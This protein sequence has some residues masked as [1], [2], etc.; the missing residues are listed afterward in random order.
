MNRTHVLLELLCSVSLRHWRGAPRLHTLLVLIIATGVAAFLA[1]RLANRAV[2]A[3]FERFAAGLSRESLLTITRSEPPLALE[4]LLAIRDAAAP[5]PIH[6]VPSI[7]RIAVRFDQPNGTNTPPDPN[8]TV[9][10]VGVDLVATINLLSASKTS[11]EDSAAP[12]P[13]SLTTDSSP[14]LAA[15]PLFESFKLGESK[16]QAR[17]LSGD[18]PVEFPL[19][20]TIPS[21]NGAPAP[22]DNLILMDLLRMSELFKTQGAFDRIDLFSSE[23]AN[24]DAEIVARA[25]RA[26]DP[27]LLIQTPEQRG[28]AAASMTRGLRLNLTILSLL[29]PKM[30]NSVSF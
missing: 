12:L 18:T 6:V 25:L 23:G 16:P 2:T 1:I 19:N 26:K 15:P 8:A 28:E 7:E 13:N 27:S 5:F 30:I 20:G 14:I 17:L 21:T 4:D 29:S 10:I 24:L 9:R 3:D 22:P 11:P